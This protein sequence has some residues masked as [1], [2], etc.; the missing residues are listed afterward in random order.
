MKRVLSFLLALMMLTL[1]TACGEHQHVCDNECDTQCNECE[2]TRTVQH[3]Y[4]DDTDLYCDVCEEY[5]LVGTWSTTIEDRPG[6]ITLNVDGTGTVTTHEATRSCTWQV[7][8]DNT[9]T[10]I[11]DVKGIPYTLF[12]GDH[13]S[14]EGNTL[15]LTS[16]SGKTLVLTKQ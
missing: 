12:N 8:V 7:G 9:L 14:V 13:F 15:T 11:Q 1:L 10:V 2:E 16:Q 5:R 4:T 6:T 3:V